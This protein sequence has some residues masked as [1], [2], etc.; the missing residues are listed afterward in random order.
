ISVSADEFRTGTPTGELDA[1]TWYTFYRP[2]FGLVGFQFADYPEMMVDANLCE[3]LVR[4]NP[5]FSL[6]P[7]L[8][9]WENVNATTVKYTIRDGAKFWDGQPVTAEDVVYSLGLHLDPTKGSLFFMPHKNVDSIRAIDDRT[10]EV[11]LQTP[12][13]TWTGHMAGPSGKIYQKA[14]T[15]AAG[16]DWGSP[17]GLVMCSGP[18]K[19]G[20][21]APGESLEIVRNDNYWNDDFGQLVRSVT[22]VWPQDPAT[23][24]NAMNSGEIDG[25][26]EIPPASMPAL[27]NGNAGKLFVGPADTSYQNFSLIVG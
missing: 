8:A 26:W 17:A 10:V 13:N 24:A 7:G 22:F 6:T 5:D 19:P 4:I 21:W 15:E 14:H 18:Y 16:G 12:D 1:I 25:G 27:R 23:V 20:K 9:S 3:S 11:K 2:A